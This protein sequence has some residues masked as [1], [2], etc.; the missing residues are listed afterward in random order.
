MS[1]QPQ[2][3]TPLPRSPVLAWLTDAGAGVPM[4]IRSTLMDEMVA[5]PRAAL[6]GPLNGMLIGAV[7]LCVTGS[8]VFFVLLAIE[9]VLLAARVALLYRNARNQAHGVATPPD[10]YLTLAIAWCG[11]QGALGW[12][13]MASGIPAVQVIAA[14]SILA[15]VGPICARNYGAPRYAMLLIALSYLPLMVGAQTLR[16][17]WLLVM[18]LQTP[19][20][21]MGAGTILQRY[22]RLAVAAMQGQA[23][24]HDLAMHDSL[25][26][27]LNRAGLDDLLGRQYRPGMPFVLLYLD[28]DG[29][30]PVND[31]FGHQAGDAVLVAVAER[32][33]NS[34]R[35][36]DIIARLGGDEFL[37]AML[38]MAQPEAH[39]L[40]EH[41]VRI[42]SDTPYKL[43]TTG[44]VRIGISIGYACAPE[45]GSALDEL[46]RKADVALYDA[47]AAGKG[48]V[49]R[50]I[51]PDSIQF[52]RRDAY[53]IRTEL[54]EAR[55]SGPAGSS[56]AA[57]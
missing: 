11:L 31:T 24:N 1:S 10:L 29:F 41:L 2:S 40:A 35:K 21:F 14:A 33:R 27:L 28:L 46:R 54:R 52:V 30:K 56:A 45:D 19:L 39:R 5:S 51:D 57:V 23:Q 25:T 8:R 37:V 55:T 48:A 53:P 13:C 15:L 50:F 43:G 22:H 36:A 6:A 34:I 3:Q 16:E 12:S 32:L 47:K 17:P 42:V 38:G 4:P 18:V 7:S 49:R 9:T 20:L 44:S 26:G